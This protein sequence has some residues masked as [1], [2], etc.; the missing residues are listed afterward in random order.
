MIAQIVNPLRALNPQARLFFAVIVGLTFVADGLYSVLL[1]LYLLRLD[2]GTEFIGLVNAVGLLTFGLASLPAGILGSRMSTT[3]LMKFGAFTC[4]A[5][6][7]LLPLAE[8]LPAGWREVGLVLPP[9]LMFGGFAFYFVNGAPYLINV[10]DD[11]Y[12]NHAFALKAAH[13]SLAGFAGSLIGGILPG[14]I[15]GLN[16]WTLADP[17]PFRITFA[18]A[19]IILALSAALSLRIR[20]LP[21][22]AA[23]KP[24][25]VDQ[26]PGGGGNSWAAS[27]LMLIVIMTVIRLFQVAGSATA[28]VY[29]NVYM[30]Q[31][32]AVSTAL[33]G[34]MAAIGRLTGVPTALLT[35][36]LVQ[37]WGNIGVVIASSMM[38]TLCLLPMALVGHWLAASFG[39]IGA[40]SMMSVRYTAFIVYILDLVPRKRQALMAGAGEAAAGMSFAMMALGGGLMLSAFTFR[41]LFLLGALISF[42][43]TALFWLYVLVNKPKRK[44]QPAL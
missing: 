14:A 21:A 43:G 28:M 25:E 5:G 37:R 9:A 22:K 30:D 42:I 36:Y 11:A 29:F 24:K 32:L 19:V 13:W 20:K 31:H 15:A 34:V 27:I 1:N 18:L 38:A 17:A 35:P 4:L 6:G 23:P 39:Y 40:V 44:L 7:L 26:R 3:A 2:Y 12:K 41:D 8:W 33:I 16:G 10:V